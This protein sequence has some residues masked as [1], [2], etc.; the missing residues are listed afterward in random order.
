MGMDLA[1]ARAVISAALAD[2]QVTIEY[3]DLDQVPPGTVWSQRP[4]AGDEVGP[5]THIELWVSRR[6][7]N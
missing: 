1:R 6:V 4:P 2:P 5:D 7:T 3:S